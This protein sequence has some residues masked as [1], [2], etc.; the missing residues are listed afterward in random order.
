M[1]AYNSALFDP[2]A[3][4]A[5]VA[6]LN[7]ES[8]ATLSDVIML[9]DSVADVTL[10][11]QEPVNRLGVSVIPGQSYELI[12]FD[13][14]PSFASAVWLEMV[15]MNGTFRGRFLLID[16]EWGILGRDILNLVSLLLDGPN[17]MWSEQSSFHK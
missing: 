16:Q 5:R 2:P 1:P 11:P 4:V 9:M 15:F 3:P 17:L 7:S 12:G 14:S 10:I 13:G 6:L 8:G